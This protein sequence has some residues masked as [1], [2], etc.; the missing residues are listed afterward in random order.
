M[1]CFY[2]S[3]DLWVTAMPKAEWSAF[4]E[5]DVEDRPRPQTRLFS[6]NI[7]RKGELRIQGPGHD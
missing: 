5:S 6:I 2:G 7:S 3:I 4:F 1:R